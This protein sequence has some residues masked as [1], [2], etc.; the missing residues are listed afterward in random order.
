MWTY[1]IAFRIAD[2]P[3]YVDRWESVVAAIRAQATGGT[4]WEEATSLIVLKSGKTAETLARDIYLDSNLNIV[5]DLLLVVN[6]NDNTHA[7]RGNIEYP[8][9]LGTFFSDGNAVNALAR[10]LMG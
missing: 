2:G 3:N 4:A 8:A 6:T 5:E 1:I 9:T 10:A 7:T